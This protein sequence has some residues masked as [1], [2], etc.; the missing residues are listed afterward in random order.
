MARSDRRFS[1]MASVPLRTPSARRFATHAAHL[2]AVVKP[3][4]NPRQS[5]QLRSDG[6]SAFC[7]SR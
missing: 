2:V 1:I 5:S 7:L 3:L 4:M 6:R